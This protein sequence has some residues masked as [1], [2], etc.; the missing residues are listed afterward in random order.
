MRLLL[1]F[2]RSPGSEPRLTASPRVLVPSTEWPSR[3]NRQRCRLSGDRRGPW[4]AVHLATALPFPNHVPLLCFW[5]K[6]DLA[7]SIC[8]WEICLLHLKSCFDSAF[9]VLISPSLLSP[10]LSIWLRRFCPSPPPARLLAFRP[11]WA[12]RPVGF[13]L[14]ALTSLLWTWA[15]W[16]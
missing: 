9:S 2:T 12:A 13:Q 16:F 8:F 7:N 11:H 14:P 4:L 6:S 3:A 10:G 1:S 5:I 15:V